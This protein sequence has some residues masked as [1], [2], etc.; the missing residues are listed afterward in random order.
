VPP[1]TAAAAAE[2]ED[3]QDDS[4]E[5]DDGIREASSTDL[6]QPALG[7]DGGD[8]A[9]DDVRWVSYNADGVA[10]DD[11]GIPIDQ[12]QTRPAAQGKKTSSNAGQRRGKQ[13]TAAAAAGAAAPRA[14][15]HEAAAAA[16]AA[17]AATTAE[18]AAAAT[19]GEAAA[20]AA[21]DKLQERQ[22]AIK[23]QCDSFKYVIK[24]LRRQWRQSAT[25]AI[26]GLGNKMCELAYK[27]TYS[28]THCIE[29]SVDAHAMGLSVFMLPDGTVYNMM[30]PEWA[31]NPQCRAAAE[32][33]AAAAR[34]AHTASDRR[35][36]VCCGYNRCRSIRL[37]L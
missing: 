4:D 11:N 15:Q 23:Q 17:A 27:L 31:A 3:E 33:A 2:N 13:R 25:S 18:E 10:Y 30:T 32:A 36:L 7:Q 5:Y 1:V 20:A 19:A 16:A 21:A 22:Q 24:K 9:G 37:T 26:I 12:S 28:A 29:N 34:A 8:P 35:M 6:L 14:A